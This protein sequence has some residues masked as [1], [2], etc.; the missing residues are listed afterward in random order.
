MFVMQICG[1]YHHQALKSRL[2]PSVHN[3]RCA[4]NLICFPSPLAAAEGA[5]TL[6]VNAPPPPG[7]GLPHICIIAVAAA[8]AVRRTAVILAAVVPIHDHACAGNVMCLR[9]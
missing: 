9:S 4:H 7:A 2:M 8:I 1:P 5:A 6:A 3:S